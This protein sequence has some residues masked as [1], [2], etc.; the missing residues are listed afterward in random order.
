MLFISYSSNE[1]NIT[2]SNKCLWFHHLISKFSGHPS[3]QT[4]L[5]EFEGHLGKEEN[6]RETSDELLQRASRIL[7]QVKAG[8]EHLADKLHHLKAVS[9]FFFNF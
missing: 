5:E 7:V 1:H 8:V 2:T 6:R 3:G 4:M 9:F